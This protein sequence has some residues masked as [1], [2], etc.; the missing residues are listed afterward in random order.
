[1][2]IPRKFLKIARTTVMGV[3]LC[4]GST[5][6]VAQELSGEVSQVAPNGKQVILNTPDNHSGEIRQ[7]T[8]RVD[9]TTDLQGVEDLSELKPGS[10]VQVTVKKPWF[11]KQWVAERLVY[12]PPKERKA[13]SPTET[14]QLHQIEADFAHGEMGDIEYETKRQELEKRVAPTS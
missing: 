13:L 12:V 3:F 4:A 10:S 8:I 14:S 11:S 6:A 2:D 5:L 9:S 7:V 1:M